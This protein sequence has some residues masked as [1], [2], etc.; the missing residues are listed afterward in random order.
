MK[1]L[2]MLLLL[3]AVA[4]LTICA[5]TA[6][7]FALK[8]E[9][10][11]FPDVQKDDPSTSWYYD[12]L[13]LLYKFEIIDGILDEDGVVRFHPTDT[14]KRS[15]FIKMLATYESLY[16]S[17]P[18]STN[19]WAET[20][21]HILDEAG[22]LEYQVFTGSTVVAEPLFE[23]SKAEMEKPI[24]RYEMSLLVTNMLYNVFCEDAVKLQNPGAAIL[25]YDSLDPNFRYSVE[26]A[27]GQGI[28]NGK[29]DGF[30]GSDTLLRRE[31]VAVIARLF[32]GSKRLEV[33]AEIE[34]PAVTVVEPEPTDFE[35][36]AFKYRTM[37]VEERRIALF[38]SASKTYFSSARDAGDNIVTVTIPIWYIRNGQ[39]LAGTTTV[40]VHRLVA[41][42]VQLI[43]Q[44]IFNDPEQFPINS[45]G[46][47]RYSDTLRHSWGC[48]IDINPNE[49]YYMHYATGQKTGSFCYKDSDSPYCIRPDGSVVRAFA[50]YGWGWGG[51][52]W[53]SGVDYMHFSILSSGG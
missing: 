10:M 51:Q 24:T 41:E 45:V 2:R 17:T 48:A 38:G 14:L 34:E 50:K 20:F 28:L 31:A 37:S 44:E 46:G 12:D 4:A 33:T 19:Y 40:Q 43:F 22:V 16:T 13:E 1:R 3:A 53:S 18:N 7:A 35:S 36:F 15:Q 9:K 27:Y 49:N 47:A 5:L 30:Q 26:Q 42:E 29:N 21:W 11:D 6:S 25:D 8:T 23:N 32:W 52:G 39:K